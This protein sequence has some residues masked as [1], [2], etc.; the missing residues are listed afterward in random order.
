MV[1]FTISRNNLMVWWQ[2]TLV[3]TPFYITCIALG[4]FQWNFPQIFYMPAHIRPEKFKQ[5][6]QKLLQL[7]NFCVKHPLLSPGYNIFS[8]I[9]RCNQLLCNRATFLYCSKNLHVLHTYMQQSWKFQANQARIFEL[10][11]CIEQLHLL[12]TSYAFLKI[13]SC[14]HLLPKTQLF[15]ISFLQRNFI[16]IFFIPTGICP[17][18]LRSIR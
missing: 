7:C 13:V 5:I 17:A 16:I 18:N 11:F 14:D 8:K 2:F 12:P 1:V 9:A 4:I 15:C 6:K 3:T 10:H